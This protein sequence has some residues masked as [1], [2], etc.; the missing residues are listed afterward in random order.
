MNYV[1]AEKIWNLVRTP[2]DGLFLDLAELG[3]VIEAIE[4]P[5]HPLSD[6]LHRFF[7][8][9]VGGSGAEHPG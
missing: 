8:L 2:F 9:G 6:S 5:V 3:N 4:S 7:L 1:H